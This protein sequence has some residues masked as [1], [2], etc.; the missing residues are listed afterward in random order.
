MIR[1]ISEKGLDLI[2]DFEIGGSDGVYYNRFL[3]KPTVPDWQNT[4]SGVTIGIGWDAGYNTNSSLTK[5][6]SEFLSDEYISDLSK[7]LGLKS[8]KAYNALREVS[9]ISIDFNIA[10]KQFLK[11]TVPRFYE[12]SRRTFPN[13]EVAPQA[14][15]DVITSL[16]FNRGSKLTGNSRIEMRNISNHMSNRDWKKISAEIRKMKRLWPNTRGLLKRRDAEAKFLD[17][18]L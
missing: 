13:F 18:N 1:M 17:D 3:K 9:H 10:K 15:K 16:V 7:V 14:V 5:E 8:R 6:W 2:L 12:L 4:Q 11:Y